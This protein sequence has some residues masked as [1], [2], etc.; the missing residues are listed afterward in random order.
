MPRTLLMLTIAACASAPPPK[1]QPAS[2][3]LR[4]DQHL[5]EARA[6]AQ[7][8]EELARWPQTRDSDVGSFDEPNTGLWYRA[9][10]QA[11]D[12]RRLA[13]IHH[14]TAA[15]LQAEFDEACANVALERVRVSPLQ[16]FGVGGMPTDNGVVIFLGPEAGPPDQLM[17][18]M[19]CHR[20][21]MMLSEA[22]MEQCPLDLPDLQVT[23]HGDRRGASVE[24]KVKDRALVPELQRRAAHELE[25]AA[26]H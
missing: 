6:H 18:E 25:V 3:G 5:D 16:R 24:I 7:R 22:G 19:R 26:R 17:A 14:G 11:R 4:A 23:A 8:A 13:A 15:Q 21:W 10:D 12:H 9:F 1:P 20:A 2:R